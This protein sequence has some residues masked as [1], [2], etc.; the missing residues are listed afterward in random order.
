MGKSRSYHSSQNI[1]TGISYK[2]F[3]LILHFISRTVFIK[4]LG[5]DYLGIN[6]LFT[7]ILTVLSLAEM[8]LGTA[9]IYSMYTP[10]AQNDQKMLSALS[11]YYKKLYTRIALVVASFGLALTPFLNNIVKLDRPI[12]NLEI[13]YL[14]FL[15]NSVLSYF[16]VYRTSIIIA[17]QQEY[18][19]KFIQM[20][21]TIVTSLLQILVLILSGDYVLYIIIQILN[22]FFINIFSAKKAV[23]RYPF[24]KEK[25]ELESSEKIE[26][27]SNIKAF[28]FYRIGGVVL[29]N[30]DNILISYILGTIWVGYYSNYSMIIA[31]VAGFTSIIFLS[32]QASFGNLNSETNEKSKYEAFS[33]LNLL[34]FWIYGFCSICF[35]VI[36]EDFIILWLGKGFLIEKSAVYMAVLTFYIQG[37]L[38]PIWIYRQT[39]GMFKYTKH[40]MFYASIINIVLSIVL[41]YKIGLTGILL[42]TVL[43]RVSTNL[44]YE[45]YILHK[46]LFKKS[47]KFYYKN[48]ILNVFVLIITYLITQNVADLILLDNNIANLIIKLSICI[49]VPNLVFLIIFNRKNEFQYLYTRSFR[50]IIKKFT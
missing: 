3:I 14:L 26:I 41:G 29:N 36:F 6:G 28:F 46:I 47:I 18:R 31:Q 38:Y 5:V 1:I 13:Y 15:L 12:E 34:S 44:W 10:L 40:I 21:F 19:L 23:Q 17:D 49:V 32:L 16:F 33:A 25:N 24:I 30:T 11:N 7:N 50:K 45:P 8:G 22:T 39:T 27:W 20:F 2:L 4:V 9:M 43:A 48:Q 37:L 42:A 35:L